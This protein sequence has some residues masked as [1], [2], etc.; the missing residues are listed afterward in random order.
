[1]YTY[2]LIIIDLNIATCSLISE[3]NTTTFL[4]REYN[5]ARKT[6]VHPRVLKVSP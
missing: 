5:I 4:I 3:K 6:C 1:M 2:T